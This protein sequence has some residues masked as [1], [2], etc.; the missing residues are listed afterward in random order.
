MLTENIINMDLPKLYLIQESL[1]SYLE[2]VQDE[3]ELCTE[4]ETILSSLLSKEQEISELLQYVDEVLVS[5]E[6]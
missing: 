1:E 2:I 4:S 5:H 6:E 3:I